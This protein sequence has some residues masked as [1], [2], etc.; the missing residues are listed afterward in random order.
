MTEGCSGYVFIQALGDKI[1][2]TDASVTRFGF[3][4]LAPEAAAGL[5]G[6]LRWLGAAVGTKDY[7]HFELERATSRSCSDRLDPL[8]VRRPD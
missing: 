2:G 5:G 3:F 7:M 1:L 6:G 8:R 4:N